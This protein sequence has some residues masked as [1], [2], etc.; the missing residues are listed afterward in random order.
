[1]SLK[2]TTAVTKGVEL[3]NSNLPGWTQHI[4]LQRL[5]MESDNQDLL[6]Q[7]ERANLIRWEITA[8]DGKAFNVFQ[9]IKCCYSTKYGFDIPASTP[10]NKKESRYRELT[11]EWRAAIRSIIL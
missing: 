11:K 7:L 8:I 9:P 5:D 4:N 2:Q 1:M 10:Q 3:L 6:G